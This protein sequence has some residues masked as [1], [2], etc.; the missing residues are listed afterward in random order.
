[1]TLNFA[2]LELWTHQRDAVAMCLD[3]FASDSPKG[4]LVQHPTGTGK[5]GIMAT[6]SALRSQAKPVLIV[7]PSA[8]LADQLVREIGGSFWEKIEAPDAWR[9]EQVFQLYPKGV[10][11]AVDL[12][13]AAGED[14]RVVA[15]TT[16]QSLQQIHATALRYE[17][18]I[19]LFGTIFFDEGHREPAPTWARAVRGLNAPTILFSA[20]PFR[21]DI[22]L[23]EID[24]GHIAFLSFRHAAEQHLIRDIEI[25]ETPLPEGLHAFAAAVIA[26]RDLAVA[27]GRFAP[28]AKVIVRANDI[29]GVRDLYDAFRAAL[30]T[31]PDGVLAVHHRLRSSGPQGGEMRPDVPADLRDRNER[32]LIHQFMLTEGIDDPACTILA[33]YEPFTTERQLVQ[34]FGR[35]TRHPEPGTPT[36][37]ALVLSCS[38]REIQR[39]WDGFLSFDQICIDNG[40]IPPI[41]ADASVFEKL[42][43]AL[44][45]VDYVDGRFRARADLSG[46]ISEELRIPK[47]ALIFEV[48]DDFDLDDLQA[49]ISERLYEEDRLEVNVDGV[50]DGACRFH[51]SLALTQSRFLSETLFLTP[52]L[53]ATVYSRHGSR[54]YF[55][56]S[57]GLFLDEIK[58]MGARTAPAAM[59]TLLPEGSK[60][61]ITQIFLKNTDLGPSAVRSRS[62]AAHSLARSGAIMGEHMNVITRAGGAVDGTRRAIAFT[63][64]RVREGEGARWNVAEFHA[65]AGAVDAELNN[66][67][68][69]SDVFARFALP[70]GIPASTVPINILLD[71]EDVADGVRDGSGTSVDFDLNSVCQDLVHDADGPEDFKYRFSLVINGDDYPVW[72]KW[73]RDKEKYWL[74][75]DALSRFKIAGSPRTSLTKRLNQRQPFRILP[76]D[77]GA[78]YAFGQFYS[79][80]LNLSVS[81]GAGPLVEGLLTG[82]SELLATKSE[83]GNLEEEADTWPEGSVFHLLDTSLVP[84]AQ[85]LP[86][87]PPFSL[88]VCDDIG[89]EAADF[90]AVDKGHG[91]SKPRIVLIAAKGKKGTA[92]VSAS[93]LYDVCGQVVKNLA[94]LKVDSQDLPGALKKWDSFWTFKGGKVPRMR[95]GTT[96]TAFRDAFRKARLN[97]ATE[98]EIWMVLGGGILSKKAVR[99][100]FAEP[101]PDAHVLQFHHLL[102]STYSACQ[103]VGVNLRI[104]CAP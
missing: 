14:S 95:A 79:I 74:R 77:L 40:G 12:I 61:R 99:R 29:D 71:I 32:Y 24:L 98:R 48:E 97:P 85:S 96:A 49:E 42:V 41:R 52:S 15:V 57:G 82:V 70:V 69:A 13:G 83:K 17:L 76:K 68:A 33:L 36:S 50:H 63:S 7:C 34:Q 75:S 46:N 44:P 6:V 20:T 59:R 8:A 66:P 80:D 47:S 102:L 9:P 51:L 89:Q 84:N 94:Y 101:A 53:E 78:I 3:Y 26:A 5:T 92:S 104:F 39:M 25:S 86:F 56:D 103:S 72:M 2:D 19:G 64:S 1:M 55:Y 91:T 16:I 27:E 31:Q 37:A 87:G 22:K 88:L 90:I 60:N 28:N 65:W 54:L 43:E 73:D 10:Q 100:E 18:L 67:K 93:D 21:N 58:G 45:P 4:G 62:Q 81:G 23:F 38:P 11:A 30:V 35:L